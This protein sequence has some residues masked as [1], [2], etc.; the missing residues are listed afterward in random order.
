VAAGLARKI[1]FTG[2]N[3][4]RKASDIEGVGYANRG[5]SGVIP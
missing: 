3:K 1:V 5:K 4:L 2:G